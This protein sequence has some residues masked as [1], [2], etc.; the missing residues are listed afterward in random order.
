MIRLPSSLC[1]TPHQVFSFPF[2]CSF[3]APFSLSS[4]GV[5]SYDPR[6]V[7]AASSDNKTQF[8]M[9][10]WEQRTTWSSK[11]RRKRWVKRKR[12]RKSKRVTGTEESRSREVWDSR[13]KKVLKKYTNE[14]HGTAINQSSPNASRNGRE[15]G[16]EKQRKERES[17]HF[18]EHFMIEERSIMIPSSSFSRHQARVIAHAS[19]FFFLS[20]HYSSL[21]ALLLPV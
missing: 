16:D 9:S 15:R 18:W 13:Q 10:S 3:T 21:F 8:Q 11:K 20:C 14:R 12:E 17:L 5:L 6:R 7:K 4:P 19:C 1:L 2:S